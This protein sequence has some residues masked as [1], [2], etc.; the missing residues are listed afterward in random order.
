MLI[1]WVAITPEPV[2]KSAGEVLW[3]LDFTLYIIARLR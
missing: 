3:L 1:L 2:W